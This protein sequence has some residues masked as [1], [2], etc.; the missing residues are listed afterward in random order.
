MGSGLSELWD[1]IFLGSL[2]Q[3][4]VR[5]SSSPPLTQ[6]GQME[7]LAMCPGNAPPYEPHPQTQD[8][9]PPRTGPLYPPTAQN[10]HLCSCRWTKDLAKGLGLQCDS[11]RARMEAQMSQEGPCNPGTL[12]ILPDGRYISSSARSGEGGPTPAV[13]SPW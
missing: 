7:L 2:K 10:Q 6:R 9:T 8:T 13:G 3:T 4:G 5:D 12:P 11:A 1:P